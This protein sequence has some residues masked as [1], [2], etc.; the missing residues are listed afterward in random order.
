M[1]QYSLSGTWK[2]NVLVGGKSGVATFEFVESDNGELIGTY[3]GQAGNAPVIGIRDRQDVNFSFKWH[4][5][6]VKYVGTVTGGEMNG[7]CI[8]GSVGEGTFCGGKIEE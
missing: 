7:T 2:L 8:Y 1:T 6:A 4:H 5:G 3:S